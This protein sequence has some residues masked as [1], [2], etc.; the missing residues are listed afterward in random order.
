[1]KSGKH[2]NDF[3]PRFDLILRERG[4]IAVEIARLQSR[5]E[6]LLREEERLRCKIAAASD[7]P[8]T[9][10]RD[11]LLANLVRRAN[12]KGLSQQGFDRLINNLARGFP[13]A[14]YGFDSEACWLLR[15]VEEWVERDHE[16]GAPLE[17]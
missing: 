11:W 2:Q 5:A 10:R 3:E 1:M 7:K 14:R 13:K 16:Y 17:N 8:M 12:G 9:V 6:Q 4:E 15:E